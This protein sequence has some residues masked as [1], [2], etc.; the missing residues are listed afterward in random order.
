M[1]RPT[2][3]KSRHRR[4]A[5]STGPRQVAVSDYDSDAAQF[6]DSRNPPP[7]P[8]PRDNTELS[9]R[10]LRRYRPSIRSILAIAS[11]AV[12]YNFLESTQGWE[13]HGAEGTMFVCEEEPIVAPTGHTLPRVCVFVLDRRSMDNL[14]IDLLRVTDCEV[15]GELIVFRFEDDSAGTGNV[16]DEAQTEKKI[17]GFWIYSDED[18]TREVYASLILSAWQQGR[19]ALDAYMQAAATGSLDN[20]PSASDS[21]TAAAAGGTDTAAGKRLSITELFGQKSAA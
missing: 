18:N 19:H 20:G 10:V 1:S 2:P 7:P 8:P 14:V 21:A 11:N 13:K 17:I 4:Q 15:V 16:G 9:L 3:R 5:S 12:A 6:S